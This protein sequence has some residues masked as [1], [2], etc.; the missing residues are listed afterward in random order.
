[1]GKIRRDELVKLRSLFNYQFGE[2]LGEIFFP[3]QTEVTHS[4][5]TGRIRDILYKDELIAVYRPRDG[6]ISLSLAGAE[7]FLNI[8]KNSPSIV[9]INDEIEKFIREGK[10]V[11]A[12]HVVKADPRIRAQDEI[13][14]VNNQRELLTVG[15]ALLSGREMLC[16]KKG[17]AV[18]VR[19]GVNN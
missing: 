2:S 10:T 12:K 19:K 6:L 8:V 4:K 16:F 15:R 7:R 1:M 18:K 14:V 11:F 13:I 3:E 9:V 17:I 5:R